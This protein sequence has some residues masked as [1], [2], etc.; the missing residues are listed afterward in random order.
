MSAM[1]SPL[2]SH[3]R[4]YRRIKIDEY[5]PW[6]VFAAACFGEEGFE[7]SQLSTI[8]CVRVWAA[9]LLQTVLE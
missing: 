5:G 8:L 4:P 7:R 3:F 1:Y 9:I 6:D 2:R